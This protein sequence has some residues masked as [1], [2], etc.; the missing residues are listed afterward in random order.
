[1]PIKTEQDEYILPYAENICGIRVNKV[2]AASAATW[3][4][5]AENIL[6]DYE[7]DSLTIQIL[8]TRKI[9]FD[10]RVQLDIGKA[11]VK[12]SK[13]ESYT[14][15]CKIVDIYSGSTYHQ[16]EL[17]TSSVICIIGV[18]SHKVASEYLWT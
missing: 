7:Q 5:E 6:G 8:P 1:M 15:H 12:C 3:T 16:C 11:T 14:K 9:N 17:Y 4:L 13:H 10:T 2:S 18:V